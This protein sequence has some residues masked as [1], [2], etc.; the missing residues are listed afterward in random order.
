MELGEKIRFAR[1]EAGFSQ[2]QLCGEEITRNMLSLIENGSA[3]PSMKT[4]RYLARQLDKPLSWFLEEDAEDHTAALESLSLLCRAR[5]ALAE[6]R[7]V[8]AAELLEKVTDPAPEIQRQKL[9]LAAQLPGTDLQKVCSQLPSLDAELMVRARAALEAG[10]YARSIHLLM[11]MEDHS[12]AAWQL[13]LGTILLRQGDYSQAI[14]PLELAL[15]AFPQ[16][17]AEKLEICYR[18]LGNFERAY[19]YACKRR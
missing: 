17:A 16:E 13:Q 10:D 9:L 19:Y 4:L 2:R 11:A 3:K 7:D 6:G 15:S 8:Y 14:S 5:Q 18:E 12:S 1:L